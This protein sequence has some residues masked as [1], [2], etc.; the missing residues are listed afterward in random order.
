MVTV[1]TGGLD[2]RN[3]QHGEPFSTIQF[4]NW[5]VRRSGDN[6]IAPG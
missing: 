5:I 1:Y 6:W 3:Y 2:D 4:K